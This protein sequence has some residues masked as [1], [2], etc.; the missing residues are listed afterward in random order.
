M[1]NIGFGEMAIICIVLII[2]VGPERLPS[3]MKT[4]GRTLR[5]LRQA[6]RDIR[7]STGIDELLRE[8]FDIYTPPPRRPASPPSQVPSA[9]DANLPSP[10][11]TPL[12]GLDTETPL[13]GLDT[14]TP[15]AGLDSGTAQTGD[16]SSLSA[17]VS[18]PLQQ[19]P[20]PL[21]VQVNQ[22]PQADQAAPAPA[23]PKPVS[24]EDMI[25]PPPSPSSPTQASVVS[26][27]AA[28]PSD[29]AAPA[30]DAVPVEPS[31]GQDPHAERKA[32]S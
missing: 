19:D 27:A 10:A 6:S 23:E 29:S 13:A 14:E 22:T 21:G 12:A 24:R 15:L 9:T 20:G 5:T 30:T 2:A 25:E 17:G 4:L 8:D 26:A 31:A 28:V 7:A 3:M 11:T 1:F 32:E 18:S 16:G